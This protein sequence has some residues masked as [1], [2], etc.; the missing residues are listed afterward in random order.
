MPV[1]AEVPRAIDTGALEQI[2]V[3]PLEEAPE[4]E[5]GEDEDDDE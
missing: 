2:L 3:Q 1:D 5:D 4:D